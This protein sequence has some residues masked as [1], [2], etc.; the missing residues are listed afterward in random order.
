VA[1][2]PAGLWSSANSAALPATSPD[3]TSGAAP[4]R[5]SF[6]VFE[7]RHNQGAGGNLFAGVLSS[8]ICISYDCPEPRR[9]LQMRA[10]RRLQYVH[11]GNQFLRGRTAVITGGSRGLGKA[12][13]LELAGAGARL[14]LVARASAALEAAA[15]EIRGGGA[16]VE[17]YPTDVTD[18][19]QV[20]AVGARRAG[21]LRARGYTREQTPA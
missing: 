9:G 4:K 7:D 18:E 10:T 19:R 3:S 16:E 13:A 5:A 21:T 20:A 17:V 15:A 6:S 12:I 2:M 1:A 14:A 11:Y 8:V